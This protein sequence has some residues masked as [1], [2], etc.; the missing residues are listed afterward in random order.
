MPSKSTKTVSGR[1]SNETASKLE[2]MAKSQGVNMS[3]FIG[4][5][6]TRL[7]SQPS[8]KVGGQIEEQPRITTTTTTSTTTQNENRQEYY[9]RKAEGY[10]DDG[11]NWDDLLRGGNY[12]REEEVYRFIQIQGTNENI[13]RGLDAGFQ[14][15]P[16]C[17]GIPKRFIDSDTKAPRYP[18]DTILVESFITGNN[19]HPILY[20]PIDRI[21]EFNDS[22]GNI[23][24]TF[25]RIGICYGNIYDGDYTT[26]GKWYI[27]KFNKGEKQY[28]FLRL[29]D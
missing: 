4:N 11:G 7:I 10:M 20:K 3:Q 22:R 9:N 2:K 16:E 1:V 5:T 28:M 17:Y 23:K 14:H 29:I 19:K 26:F 15:F 25:N 6:L 27:E 21:I 8:Q 12:F 13:R 18:Y 24:F